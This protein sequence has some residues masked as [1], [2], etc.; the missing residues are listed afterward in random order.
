MKRK[1]QGVQNSKVTPSEKELKKMIEMFN[2]IMSS[3]IISN[4]KP[5]NSVKALGLW[6]DFLQEDEIM[7]GFRVSKDLITSL[8]L[9]NFMATPEAVA[10]AKALKRRYGIVW[11]NAEMEEDYP[12]KKEI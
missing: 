5:E 12:I 7:Q 1:N 8:N 4:R 10:F 11:N 2:S 6:H 9:Q 3:I